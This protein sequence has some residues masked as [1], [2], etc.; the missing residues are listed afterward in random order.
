MSRKIEKGKSIL[1]LLDYKTKTLSRISQKNGD[2]QETKFGLG[3]VANHVTDTFKKHWCNWD[4]WY[5]KLSGVPHK[6]ERCIRKKK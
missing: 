6:A 1:H 4:L 3:L 2:G 5:I